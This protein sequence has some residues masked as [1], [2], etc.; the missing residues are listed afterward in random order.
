M[1]GKAT[2]ILPP[3][4]NRNFLGLFV[5]LFVKNFARDRSEGLSRLLFG[6][7]GPARHAEAVFSRISL[8]T[9]EIA[10]MVAM[11]TPAAY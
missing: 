2:I 3:I 5:Q 8:T 11:T 1:I 7:V 9:D 10:T 6:E 4:V